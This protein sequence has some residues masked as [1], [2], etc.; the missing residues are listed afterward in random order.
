[1]SKKFRDGY[2]VPKALQEQRELVMVWWDCFPV[3]SDSDKKEKVMGKSH[4]TMLKAH[5]PACGV[6]HSVGVGLHKRLRPVL[7]RETTTGWELCLKCA[8]AIA[9]GYSLLIVCDPSKSKLE[10]N[11]TMRASGAYRTGE[12]LHVKNEAWGR[13]FNVPHPVGGFVFCDQSVVLQLKAM[14]AKAEEQ[15]D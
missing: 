8:E 13:I 14:A 11:G 7:E 6:E 1:M 5:C 2:R 3:L 9:S 15:D 10:A 4:V 12:L